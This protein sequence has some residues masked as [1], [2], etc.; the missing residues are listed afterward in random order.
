MI[1]EESVRQNGSETKAIVAL[2]M[3]FCLF[4]VGP[5]YAQSR[6]SPSDAVSLASRVG[7]EG[8]GVWLNHGGIDIP[9][10]ELPLEEQYEHIEGGLKYYEAVRN[11]SA[12][13]STAISGMQ[14][15]MSA[16]VAG[17]ILY[18]GPQAAA[19][20]PLTLIGAI[21]YTAYDSLYSRFEEIG[22]N[23]AERLLARLGDDLAEAA[24]VEDFDALAKKP[25]LLRGTIIESNRFLQDFKRRASESGDQKLLNT[26]VDVIQRVAV[27]TDAATLEGLVETDREVSELEAQFGQFVEAIDASNKQIGKRMDEHGKLI[28]TLSKDLGA[29]ENDVV[30]VNQQVQR[31]GKNQDL[32]ADFM[33]SGLPPDEKARALRSG[34]IDDRIRCPQDK[35]DCNPAKVKAALVKGYE[36]QARIMKNV[37][38]AGQ[39]L[40]GINDIGTIAG[41]LGLD[42][43]EDGNTAL[44]IASGAT[45]MYIGLM[46][47]NPLGAIASITGMFGKRPDP[48]AERFRIMMGVLQEQFGIIN[49]KLDAVLNNQQTILDAVASVSKQLEEMY[50]HLD[51]RLE[52]MAWEQ[53]RISDNLKELIWAEW[54][55]CFS[56]Y[57]Y[58]LAPNPSERTLPFADPKTLRFKTFE[59]V[60]AVIDQRGNQISRCLNTVHDAMGS[61]S[62][63]KWFGTFLD[64]RRALDSGSVL[65]Q[66]T[67]GDTVADE[68]ERW[69]SIERLHLEDVVAPARS[70][71]SDWA[72]RNEVAASTLLQLQTWRISHATQLDNIIDALKRGERFE[73]ESDSDSDD[74]TGRVTR[75]LVCI[76]EA[77]EGTNADEIA[78]DLMEF[79][80]NVDILLEIS[81]WMRILSQVA[82]LYDGTDRFAESLED[83]ATFRGTSH[84]EEITRMTVTMMGLAIAYYSRIYGGITAL[85]L[86]EDIRSDKADKRHETALRNNPYLAENTALLLLHLERGAW[87]LESEFSRPSFEDVYSQALLHARSEAANRFMPLYALFGRN[88]TFTSNDDGKIGL[89]VRIGDA[90]AFLPLSPPIRLSKGQF[91]FPPR[92]HA[93]TNRQDLFINAY[94]DYRLGSRSS[95]V[96]V[97]LQR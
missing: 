24:Q 46:T 14:V 55:P 68:A 80:I 50:R 18:A 51:G 70:I 23:R 56:M 66:G 86:A 4:V 71:V 32:V 90:D 78:E 58:A 25:D 60:R 29:L 74:E 85:A 11:G 26:A 77:T 63:T 39:I 53:R 45:N 89:S 54:M 40:Q 87:N 61:V 22:R 42:L 37:A 92:Y 10:S 62:A 49:K 34:L 30:A 65:D 21:S 41:N 81:S 73:C 35:P 12:G 36:G 59:D 79:A 69:R 38:Y 19:T 93:L 43:G 48:D 7:I 8:L 27:A 1:M 31:L 6:I 57:R 13:L 64:A 16:I 47:N 97:V 17:A 94:V 83:L 33:F 91:M 76:S 2:L 52:S 96:S 75:E 28:Q 20:V 84:G 72:R 95:L 88:Y 5:V 9:P 82:S 44:R 15:G 3:A 67:L